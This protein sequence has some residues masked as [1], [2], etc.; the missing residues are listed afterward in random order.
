MIIDLDKM[1]HSAEVAIHFRSNDRFLHRASDHSDLANEEF[2]GLLD[3]VQTCHIYMIGKRPRVSI[4]PGT[5][6]LAEERLQL[7]ISFRF[8][9]E[10]F[11]FP[12]SY[13]RHIFRPEEVSFEAA[14]F[15]HRELISRNADGRIIVKTL[16]ANHV[17]LFDSLPERARD[18]EILYIGKGTAQ[19]ASDR[20]ESHSTLQHIL[21]DV[22]ANDPESEIF[23]LLYSFEFKKPMQAM[24][25]RPGFDRIKEGAHLEAVRAY[26]PSLVDKISLVEASCIGYF[27]PPYNTQLLTFP[28][29][30]L[31][32]RDRAQLADF[33]CILVDIDNDPIGGARVFS[34]H[35]RTASYHS[36]R[37]DLREMT[38]AS[39]QGTGH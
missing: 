15:P 7:T 14:E 39:L 28:K 25:G 22:S 19:S 9:G 10:E 31:A 20:L 1:R 2:Q 34:S 6:N 24:K 16:L 37:V 3:R 11:R 29:C 26:Q 27:R 18:I 12:I 35:V 23:I 32:A 4:V 33:A 36:F 30:N 21:G 38:I 17:H 13:P 5:V 8:G